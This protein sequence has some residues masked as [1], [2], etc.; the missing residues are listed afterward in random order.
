VNWVPF[1][2]P[3]SLVRNPNFGSQWRLFSA[4]PGDETTRC[5]T[6]FGLSNPRL[7]PE[8]VNLFIAKD[9]QRS[10]KLAALVDWF[11]MYSSPLTGEIGTSAVIYTQKQEV[12]QRLQYLETQFSGTVM[13]AQHELLAETF[14][15]TAI[16]IMSRQIAL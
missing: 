4:N 6:F 13:Q 14:P 1:W 10:E 7:L 12:M 3:Q 2:E 5:L 11:G 16:R 8:V 15:R 9:D